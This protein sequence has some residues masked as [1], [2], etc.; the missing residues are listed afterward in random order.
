M[1]ATVSLFARAEGIAQ[2]ARECAP[3]LPAVA[4]LSARLGVS[5]ATAY[6]YRA[7]LASASSRRRPRSPLARALHIES[8]SRVSV[9]SAQEIQLT[10]GVSRSTAYRY[11]ARFRLRADVRAVLDHE[12]AGKR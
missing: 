3:A 6:R 9:P 11:V 2:L 12:A 4:V 7:K 8:S 5:R 10:F 1:S